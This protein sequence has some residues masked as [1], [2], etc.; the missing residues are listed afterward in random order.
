MKNKIHNEELIDP[1]DVLSSIWILSCNDENAIMT[2]EGIKYRINPPNHIDIKELIHSRGELFRKSV[3]A[4]RL[5]NWKNQML[6]G[7]HL[8]SYLRNIHDTNERNMLINSIRPEDT[9]RNQFRAEFSAPKVEIEVLEWGLQHIDRI[10]KS[11]S[12]VKEE[13]FKKWSSVRIPLTSAIIALLALA[14]TAYTQYLN[15]QRETMRDQSQINLKYY[16][17]ELKPK[18]DKQD[19]FTES[20]IKAIDNV[21]NNKP[22]DLK[23][24]LINLES[25]YLGLLRFLEENN[26][27]RANE[28]FKKLQKFKADCLGNINR[29]N[30]SEAEK[31]EI[32]KLFE[33]Y[34]RDFSRLLNITLFPG[35]YK[36][37]K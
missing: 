25:A 7:K 28:I 34:K 35:A 14:L 11:R 6:A 22:D 16:E 10:R 33:G 24:E 31:D 26:E 17:V 9:F 32:N 29:A 27:Y 15:T 37:Q 1:L 30:K 3:P 21:I 18:L 4:K 13:E 19:R 36:D 8:P 12:E 5:E 23:N 20:L 2:C